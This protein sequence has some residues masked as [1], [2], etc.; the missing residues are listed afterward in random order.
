[1]NDEVKKLLKK[2]ELV[3]KHLE[4]DLVQVWFF[5]YND[6]TKEALEFMPQNGV[7]WSTQIELDELLEYVNLRRLPKL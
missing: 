2:A 4:A 3:K 1:M 7:F 6:F 5:S